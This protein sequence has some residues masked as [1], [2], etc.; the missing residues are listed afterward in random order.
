MAK[1]KKQMTPAQKAAARKNPNA[2]KKENKPQAPSPKDNPF[3]GM[4][5]TF[6]LMGVILIAVF[7][8]MYL[9]NF[10]GMLG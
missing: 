7:V 1:K 10:F 8:F 5:F 4:G 9:N 2:P 3:G 6:L